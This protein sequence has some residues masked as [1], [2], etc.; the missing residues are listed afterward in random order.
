MYHSRRLLTLALALSSL[1]TAR[2]LFAQAQRPGNGTRPTTPATSGGFGGGFGGG[3]AAASSS[4]N[5]GPRQYRSN[6]LL[7]D[8]TIEVDPETR[9]LIIVTDEQTELELSK[10]IS[11]LD[12]PKPQVL[13]KVVFLEVTWDRDSDIGIE[14]SY[15]FNL[16]SPT[17]ASTGPATTSVT[18]TAATGQAG[19][20]T[21]TTTTA[22]A[23]PAS[24][25][26]TVNLSNLYGLS[27]LTSGSFVRLASDNWSATLHALASNGKTEVLSRPTIMARNNQQAVIIVGQEVPFVT[28]S[29]VTD[30][31]Q[32]INTVSYDNV[33]IIL[34]VTPFITNNNQIEMIVAPEISALTSQTVAISD[35][36]S[37]PVISKRSAETV[38]VT[39]DGM[40]SVIGGLM[41]KQKTLSV[42]KI[43]YLGDIPGLGLLFKHTTRTET[44]T[45]LLIFL[46]PYIVHDAED[47]ANVTNDEGNRTDLVHKAF[48]ERELSKFLEGTNF[49]NRAVEGLEPQK[50]VKATPAPAP[51]AATPTVTRTRIA[52]KKATPA[53]SPKSGGNFQ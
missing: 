29:R 20:Q 36:L 3:G 31:G 25:G 34:T 53:P 45:E 1:A 47:L 33:G 9:S 49:D 23:I 40:T 26:K 12:Q 5:S 22:A 14:G 19:T 32:T 8:A 10:V 27:Q 11:E 37:S 7:G 51:R 18:N 30:T 28:N 44:K 16:K 46:T 42:D 35:T 21:T 39:P 52:L 15:T 24:L 41:Q 4:A 48:T 13:I 17:A 50:K 38:V 2:P 6:T 43:P